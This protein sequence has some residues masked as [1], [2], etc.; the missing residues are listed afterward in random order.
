MYEWGVEAGSKGGLCKYANPPD[1]LPRLKCPGR[2]I[3][4]AYFYGV[5]LIIWVM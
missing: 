3:T 4:S 5:I 1:S 2:T